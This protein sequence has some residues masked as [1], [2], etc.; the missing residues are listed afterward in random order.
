MKL[1]KDKD[2]NFYYVENK[3]KWYETPYEEEGWKIIP[4][5]KHIEHA[6]LIERKLNEVD[7]PEFITDCS[8]C[9]NKGYL[10][11]NDD[12]VELCD[13]FHSENGY[14][15]AMNDHEKY[16]EKSYDI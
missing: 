16:K 4:A 10:S 3:G 7:Y 6:G 12:G 11:H 15:N 14:E 13:C 2:K 8:I 9:D 5:I 1:Y